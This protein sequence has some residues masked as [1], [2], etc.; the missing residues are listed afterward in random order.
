[1]IVFNLFSK[2]V[3]TSHA[4][5]RQ[6]HN[7]FAN[8]S[9]SI[10]REKSCICLLWLCTAATPNGNSFCFHGFC[11]LVFHS[12]CHRGPEHVARILRALCINASCCHSRNENWESGGS[13]P[14]LRA[15][16]FNSLKMK[17][18]RS[19]M[20]GQKQVQVMIFCRLI[21]K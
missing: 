3:L 13:K 16:E 12:G 20:S 18:V 14:K 19:V 21:S 9:D 10:L 8:Y 6:Q 2:Q 17:H 11:S 1:M 4:V 5:V 7:F 15:R